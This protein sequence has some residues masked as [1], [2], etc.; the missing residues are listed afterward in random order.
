MGSE[1][2]FTMWFN[3]HCAVDKHMIL[4]GLE[5]EHLKLPEE[6]GKADF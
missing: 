3:K 1:V 6:E 2:T 4:D 5:G